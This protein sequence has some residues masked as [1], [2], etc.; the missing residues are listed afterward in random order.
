MLTAELEYI[1]NDVDSSV[2]LIHLSTSEPTVGIFL[3]F[4]STVYS[5]TA[6]A[7][8]IPAVGLVYPMMPY[9]SQGF[10]PV[11]QQSI[12]TF[13]IAALS[14]TVGSATTDFYALVYHDSSTPPSISVT[15]S[16][17]AISTSE[18]TKIQNPSL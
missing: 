17:I 5:I 1:K 12:S 4:S 16:L 11:Q 6:Q 9:D 18:T 7:G 3:N 10:Y 14:A 8:R 13:A 15:A 2:S